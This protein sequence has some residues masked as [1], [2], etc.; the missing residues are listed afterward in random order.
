MNERMEDLILLAAL[1]EIS[2][3]DQ[4]ELDL[5]AESDPEVAV[6][7]AAELETSALLL[8]AAASPAPA[9]LRAAVLA[10]VDTTLQDPVLDARVDPELAPS[11]PTSVTATD[12]ADDAD[13]ADEVV[14]L[15]ARRSR[16]RWLVPALSAAA[17]VVVLAV[18]AVVVVV[19]DDEADPIAAVVD[20]DDVVR[21]PLAGELQ[22]TLAVSYSPGEEAIVI[23]GREIPSVAADRTYVLWFINGD[24]A[25][26]VGEFRPDDSGAVS[27]RLDGLDPS[28]ADLGVTEEVA[29]EIDTPTEPILAVG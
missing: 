17:A 19:G 6:E 29:A 25:T 4:R 11:G 20:A 14:S 1:G 15:A 5:A 26:P 9:S 23:D 28:G 18:G 7:L 3:A 22:G 8:A 13:D 12:D 27:V 24:E 2:A 10:E 21:R 16:R